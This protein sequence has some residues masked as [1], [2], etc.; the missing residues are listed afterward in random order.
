MSGAE[1]ASFP[2]PGRIRD[3]K[4]VGEESESAL[5]EDNIYFFLAP[6]PCTLP[7]NW[8]RVPQKYESLG[9]PSLMTQARIPGLLH[10]LEFN[11]FQ[12]EQSC[13]TI[14]FYR[15]CF[16]QNSQSEFLYIRVIVLKIN[17]ASNPSI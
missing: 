6:P 3:E 16:P 8:A 7:K 12:G 11:N 13:R 9:Y 17:L 5:G 1:R 2:F 4:G 15:N 14:E 10:V